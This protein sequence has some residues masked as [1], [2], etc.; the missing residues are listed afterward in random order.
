MFKKATLKSKSIVGGNANCG[1]ELSCKLVGQ[2][3]FLWP[4]WPHFQQ[5]L[6]DAALSKIIICSFSAAGNSPHF[7]TGCISEQRIQGW[8]KNVRFL[9]ALRR[10]FASFLDSLAST[11]RYS[12]FPFLSLDSRLLPACFGKVSCS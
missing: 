5:G 7:C 4:I 2:S 10:L 11:S 8:S 3:A 12:C 6:N 1:L 9:A